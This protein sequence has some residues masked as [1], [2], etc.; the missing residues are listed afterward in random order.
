MV[1]PFQYS[2]S[3]SP[4]FSYLSEFDLTSILT[5]VF[6]DLIISCWLYIFINC[7]T[8]VFAIVST[9]TS[10]YFGPSIPFV[11]FSLPHNPSPKQQ[12]KFFVSDILESEILATI[13]TITCPGATK[14]GTIPMAK[15]VDTTIWSLAYT[16][17]QYLWLG[18]VH[19]R[20][21]NQHMMQLKTYY[22]R[23]EF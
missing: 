3:Y 13:C 16:F 2:S 6:Q 9:H 18:S 23:V 19:H 11:S 1:C 14:P 21:S 12:N 20:N 4:F 15:S 5:W 22:T 10:F 8:W 17:S 7:P